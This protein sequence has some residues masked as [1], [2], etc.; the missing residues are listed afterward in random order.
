MQNQD[1]DQRKLLS[2][3]CHGAVLFS[4]TIV[5][6]GIPIVVL[7]ITEDPIVKAN[8]KEAL[9]FQ[10][11]IFAGALI[12]FVLTFVLIGIFLFFGLAIFSV[13]MPIIAIVKVIDK[14]DQPYRY[15][16]TLR[17]I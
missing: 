12:C 2:A 10:I 1:I 13:I 14:P 17:L 9:N 6:V 5:S 16:L 8:A 15:P 3:L 11:S 7:A 4:A